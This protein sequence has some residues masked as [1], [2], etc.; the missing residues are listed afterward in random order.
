MEYTDLNETNLESILEN[1]DFSEEE[2]SKIKYD[3]RYYDRYILIREGPNIG[4]VSVFEQPFDD[5]YL[6]LTLDRFK[7]L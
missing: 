2:I 6:T 7:Y 1:L 3:S 4:F 5:P